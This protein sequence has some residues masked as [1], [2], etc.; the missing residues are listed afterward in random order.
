MNINHLLI[1]AGLSSPEARTY[2]TLYQ[3]Q[4]SQSGMLAEQ[5]NVHLSKI[6]SVL[7]KLIGKGLVSYRIQNNIKIFQAA[8][9]EALAQLI[10]KKEEEL[11]AQKK[12][13]IT[14][15]SQLKQTKPLN[16]PQS[17]YKYYDGINGVKTLWN[18]VAN[19]MNKDELLI[20]TGKEESNHKLAAIYEEFHNKRV[21]KEINLKI[22]HPI[23]DKNKLPK[24]RSLPRTE[25]R[26]DAQ[27]T[28][29]EIGVI[30]DMVV[31]DHV[32]KNPHGFLIVD[33][34]FAAT[35]KELF[36]KLYKQ[37]KK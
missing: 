3:L 36:Y 18:E 20:Y 11:I 27:N 21:K 15:I 23:K 5:A 25:I 6:Y 31:L 26:F 13:I 35:F 37:A 12:Q 19:K 17:R 4:E 8:P 30:N 28:L 29:C 16:P 1:E 24:R 22:I 34:E 10:E 7:E 32:G 2:I 14:A 9:P 33:K